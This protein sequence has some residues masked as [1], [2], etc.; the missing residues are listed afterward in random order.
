ME[1]VYRDC[2][3]KGCGHRF[4]TCHSVCK[5]YKDWK[6]E[7]ELMKESYR[8]KRNADMA[9]VDSKAKFFNKLAKM[10]RNRR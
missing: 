5:D 3:C 9:I 6:A 8:L 4:V 2:P 7:N 10:R 1:C